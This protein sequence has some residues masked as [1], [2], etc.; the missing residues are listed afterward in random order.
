MCLL[1]VCVHV[2]IS[3]HTN[4]VECVLPLCSVVLSRAHHHVLVSFP[5][6]A[7]LRGKRV[8]SIFLAFLCVSNHV[9]HAYAHAHFR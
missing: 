8:W 2:L 5:D 1:Y 6:P 7:P 3:V 4:V 9:T